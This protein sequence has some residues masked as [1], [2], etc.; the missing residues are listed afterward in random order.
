MIFFNLCFITNTFSLH[1][2]EIYFKGLDGKIEG[3]HESTLLLKKG[4]KYGVV[5]HQI[6][7][8]KKAKNGNKMGSSH[9]STLVQKLRKIKI[10]H[11]STLVLK[12][13]K[14]LGKIEGSHESTLKIKKAKF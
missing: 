6:W 7:C 13:D 2:R 4:Q 1:I 12:I 3:R 11:E 10:S 5:I 9:E 8:Y 14:N